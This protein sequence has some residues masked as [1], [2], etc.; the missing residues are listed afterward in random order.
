MIRFLDRNLPSVIVFFLIGMTFVAVL[1]AKKKT[2][3]QHDACL[4]A[5]FELNEDQHNYQCDNT[6]HKVL[7]SGNGT[8]ICKC[9][10]YDVAEKAP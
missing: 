8:W 6:Q 10:P 7:R 9:P 3:A 4:E 2:P 1:C 5:V